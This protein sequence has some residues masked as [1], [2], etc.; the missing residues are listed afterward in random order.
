VPSDRRV[1]EHTRVF[2]RGNTTVGCRC[3]GCG[4]ICRRL[5]DNTLAIEL[6]ATQIAASFPTRI[7]Q[8][9]DDGFRLGPPGTPLTQ[10]SLFA[11]LDWRYSLLSDRQVAVL[12]AVSV[13]ASAF[14]VDGAPAVSNGGPVAFGM[15]RS[16][17][18][19]RPRCRA[20]GRRE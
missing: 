4:G 6:T 3:A 9:L 2:E 7:L 18:E 20:K 17:P 5:D 8:I 16:P 14:G 1:P 13:F 15:V 11:T 12:Q 19:A 10:Q